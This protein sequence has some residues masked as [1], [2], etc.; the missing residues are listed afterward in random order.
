MIHCETW[1][2][3]PAA[4]YMWLLAR[5]VAPTPSGAVRRLTAAAEHLA[6]RLD[7]DP[8]DPRPFPSATLRGWLDSGI[9]PEDVEHRLTTGA[10]VPEVVTI[11]GPGH[12]LYTLAVM[13]AGGCVCCRPRPFTAATTA[14]PEGVPA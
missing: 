7:E 10:Y 6:D 8:A 14:H 4:P 5:D 9:G 13:P 2:G 1:A 11:T 3:T 12:V